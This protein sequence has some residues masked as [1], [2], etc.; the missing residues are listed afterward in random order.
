VLVKDPSLGAACPQSMKET[1][2]KKKKTC[3]NASGKRDWCH[4]AIE[5]V[6]VNVENTVFCSFIETNLPSS[7][8]KQWYWSV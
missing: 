4:F 1:A 7:G 5:A 2:L 3:A 8:L 6:L